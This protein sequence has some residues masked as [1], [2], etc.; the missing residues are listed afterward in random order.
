MEHRLD[1]EQL[2]LAG[3]P[4]HERQHVVTTIRETDS[5][6]L[7]RIRA[8]RDPCTDTGAGVNVE[9]VEDVEDRGP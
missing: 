7:R 5:E 3:L 2:L 8:Q 4:E 9:D 6:K 1:L